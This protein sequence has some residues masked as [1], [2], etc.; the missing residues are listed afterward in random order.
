[1]KKFKDTFIVQQENEKF[2]SNSND[3]IKWFMANMEITDNNND[4][5]DI[6]KELCMKLK[7]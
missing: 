2:I 4:K 3:Y 7:N 1:M 5:I 6:D